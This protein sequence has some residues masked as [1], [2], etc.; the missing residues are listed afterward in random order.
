MREKT[1]GMNRGM[2]LHCRFPINGVGFKIT[3]HVYSSAVSTNGAGAMDT[4]KKLRFNVVLA[5]VVFFFVAFLKFALAESEGTSEKQGLEKTLSDTMSN[6]GGLIQMA[7]EVSVIADLR[8]VHVAAS[9]YF[10]E[11]EGIGETITVEKLS[12]LGLLSPLYS[13]G[14]KGQYRFTIEVKPRGVGV[15]AD[16]IDASSKLKHFYVDEYG[17]LYEDIGKPATNESNVRGPSLELPAVPQP[18]LAAAE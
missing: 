11:Y 17:D 3:Y 15:H 10:A 18:D 8:Q 9:V 16:P 14:V 2:T 13:K 12:E 5:A 6:T 4:D 1:S 7:N